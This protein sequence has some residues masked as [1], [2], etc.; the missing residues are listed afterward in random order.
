MKRLGKRKLRIKMQLAVIKDGRVIRRTTKQKRTAIYKEIR[1][2]QTQKPSKWQICVVYGKAK[3]ASGE[4]AEIDN[5]GEYRTV[6]ELLGALGVFTEK[7]L[8][9][10][11]EKWI[12]EL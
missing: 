5:C 4:I 12:G 11:T 6:S 9:D 7:K 10:E 3:T 1:E 2:F 8:L